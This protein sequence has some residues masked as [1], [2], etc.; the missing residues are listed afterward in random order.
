MYVFFYKN[1]LE[2]KDKISGEIKIKHGFNK[3][4]MDLLFCEKKNTLI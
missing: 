3:N 4:L 2:K 1:V